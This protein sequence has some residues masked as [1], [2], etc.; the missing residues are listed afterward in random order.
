MKI[1]SP[2]R[3]LVVLIIGGVVLLAGAIMIFTPGPGVAVI[4]VGLA[5]LASEFP[6]ARRLLVR[7]REEAGDRGR[8][9]GGWWRRLRGRDSEGS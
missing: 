4:L 3:R 5:T 9:A 7:I 2:I 1:P 6:W 8:Q